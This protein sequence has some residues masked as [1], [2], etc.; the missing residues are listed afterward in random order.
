[1]INNIEIYRTKNNIPNEA[2]YLVFNSFIPSKMT[3]STGS[4][5]V[6]WVRVYKI[7]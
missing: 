6:D 4:L 2:M 1:M 7:D 5:E 3:G